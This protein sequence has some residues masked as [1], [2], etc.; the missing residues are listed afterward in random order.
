MEY[1]WGHTRRF[2]SYS[3]FMKRKFGSRVQKLSL[4]AGFTCPNRDGTK[5]T[6]GCTF[7]NNNAFNPSYCDPAKGITW[8][9]DEGIKFHKRRYRKSDKFLAY[10]QAYTNSYGSL[11]LLKSLYEEALGHPDVIGMVIGT[12]PDTVSPELLDYLQELSKEYYIVI[13]YGVESY[14]NKTLERINRG[15]TIEDSMK[16]VEETSRR[17][18]SQGVHFIIGL[19]GESEDE[20]ISGMKKISEWPV[21]KIKFHQL[22]IVKNTVMEKEYNQDPESFSLFGM[23]EYLNL[24]VR[25]TEQLNPHFVIERIAGEVNPGFQAG[26]EWGLRYDQVLRRFEEK[27]EEKDTWQ[28]KEFNGRRF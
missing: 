11:D 5:G 22:Q 28:G 27:L 17:G 10:F 6:G 3:E 15:H 14:Y 8:Q 13:E 9:L 7:C 2:N 4:D 19:P 25:I 12:R 20:I 18:L 16:A 21:D 26:P 1:P 23:D 24:M